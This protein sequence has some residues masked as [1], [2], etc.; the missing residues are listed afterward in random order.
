MEEY[1]DIEEILKEIECY[2][3]HICFDKKS[4]AII[5]EKLKKHLLLSKQYFEL[6][7]KEKQITKIIENFIGLYFKT[8]SEQAKDFL[9]KMIKNIVMF[10]DLGKLNFRFQRDKM[11]NKQCGNKIIFEG[12]GSKHSLISAVLYF[13]Y[14]ISKINELTDQ[15]EKKILRN[16]IVYHS[17]VIARHHGNLGEFK[18]YLEKYT[19]E[20]IYN[21]DGE[22]IDIIEIFL[23]KGEEIFK[24]PFILTKERVKKITGKIIYNYISNRSEEELILIYG[25][26]RLLYSILVASD[27]YATTEFMS[28]IKINQLGNIEQID[29]LMQVF[30]ET[31]TIKSIRRYEKEQF[32]MMQENLDKVDNINILRNEMFLEAEKNLINNQDNTIFYLEA[33]TGSGKSNTGINLSFQLIK[34]NSQLKKIFYVYPFNTLVE[35]NLETLKRTFE[36]HPSIDKDITVINSNTPIKKQTT[37][38]MEE[39]ITLYQKALLDRQFL[40]Y[41]IILTTHVSLFNIL[42]SDNRESLFSFHQLSNS[43]I[44]LDE[45]QSYRNE[46]WGEIIHFFKTLAPFLNLKIIIMSATLPNLDYL[47]SEKNTSIS[48]ITNREKYFSHPCFKNRVKLSYE[49]LEKKE[50]K[51]ELYYH[52]KLMIK[53]NNNKKILIEFIRKDTASNF[54][55]R[56]KED[57]EIDSKVFYISGDDNIHE[58]SMILETIKKSEQGNIILVS[59]QVIENGIDID[60]DIGYKDISKL[61]SE[62]QFLGRI[63]RSFLK[64]K[65]GIVYFFDWDNAENIYK[66]DVRKNKNYTLKNSANREILENK[67][68]NYYYLEI[69]KE[70]KENSKRLNEKNLEEFFKDKV[71][72]LNFIDVENRMKLIEDDNWAISIYL[73]RVLVYN[74]E[75]INGKEIWSKYKELLQNFEMDYAK[76]RVKLSELS[77]KMNFFIYQIKVKTDINYNDKIGDLYYIED[78]EKYFDNGKIDREKFNENFS[79][80][81]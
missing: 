18:T 27:Y 79:L 8:L 72:K 61:D 69:L 57:N 62:E 3:A 2:D 75:T 10:H 19:P 25:Y 64:G 24:E 13:N 70:I 38:E 11:K 76:K 65:Q 46:I 73:A 50:I 52:L 1:I 17:Y 33:P 78:G 60:M 43:V 39:D 22:A 20:S 45:I 48:L 26:I 16:F 58:R 51:E 49:L 42:F 59:T 74:K 31:D 54:Y 32:P 80:I 9:W 55:R 41:P 36:N 7:L 15:E 35:Q 23:E 56:L 5:R 21:L 77:A 63:N 47:I 68:F 6:L 71:G 81:D 4:G 30:N 34:R 14:F 28:G 53:Q 67:N 40:N 12:M 66:K 29:N 37:Q 44:V